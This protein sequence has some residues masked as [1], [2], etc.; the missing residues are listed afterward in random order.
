MAGRAGVLFDLDGVIIDSEELQ[1]QAY[2]QV[3]ARFGVQVSREEYGREWIGNGRGA[4]YAV[5]TYHLPLTPEELRQRRSEIYFD[6]LRGGVSLMPGV[7]SALQRLHPH[8]GLA[9]A[10]NSNRR[11]TIFVLEH[12]SVRAYFSAVVTREMYPQAKPE[13]DAFLAAARALGLAPQRC[14]VIE[15]AFKGVMAATRAGCKCIVVP[16][17]FT[18]RNDFSAATRIVSSLDEVTVELVDELAGATQ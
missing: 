14:I 2:Q 4:E 7:V 3:L 11:D 8:F 10:T 1:Y 12:L 17:D 16:H 6:L 5:V 13:P 18:R 15:D 9:L